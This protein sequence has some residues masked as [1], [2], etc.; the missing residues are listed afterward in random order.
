MQLY[1]L[2]GTKPMT[3]VLCRPV[4]INAAVPSDEEG[5]QTAVKNEV[6]QSVLIVV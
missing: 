4:N 6:N 2:Q 1:L 5:T 3:P